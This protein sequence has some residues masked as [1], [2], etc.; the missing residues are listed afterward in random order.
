MLLFCVCACV[1]VHGC[2]ELTHS[3]CVI[4]LEAAEDLVNVPGVEKP[5]ASH[6]HLETL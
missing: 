4:Q 1:C 5:I 2:A 3:V 6:H